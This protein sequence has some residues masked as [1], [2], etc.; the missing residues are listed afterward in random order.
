MGFGTNLKMI[1]KRK[2]I[3]IKEL[4]SLTGI[5]LNTLYSITKRDTR[6]PNEDIIEKISTALSIKKSELLTLDVLSTEI[7]S[8]LDKQRETEI[9]LRNKLSNILE[10]LSPDAL[11]ILLNHSLDLLKY[12]SYWSVF[13]DE[14]KIRNFVGN[15]IEK[16]ELPKDV[17]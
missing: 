15:N 8:L 14:A 4:S 2:G 6:L 17:L 7:H 12:E 3:S 11:N 13:Y 9:N 10:M 1:L 5:S 16:L